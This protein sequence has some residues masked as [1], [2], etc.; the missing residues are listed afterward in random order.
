MPNFL[1]PQHTV[2]GS[3][4]MSGLNR[5][6]HTRKEGGL[7]LFHTSVLNTKC[8]S[9]QIKINF[10]NILYYSM[11]FFISFC[12]IVLLYVL[13]G[14]IYSLFMSL[15]Q[16]NKFSITTA[17]KIPSTPPSDI[18]S[19][20]WNCSNRRLSFY[21]F[22]KSSNLTII[23]AIHFSLVSYSVHELW[24]DIFTFQYIYYDII[25]ISDNSWCTKTFKKSS[26]KM[27]WN[28]CLSVNFK[29]TGEFNEL[30]ICSIHVHLL[31]W[32][33]VPHFYYSSETGSIQKKT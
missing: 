3:R 26:K 32:K 10:Y 19:F 7:T 33:K 2:A 1:Q 25:N 11:W 24:F 17:V 6:G 27:S 22:F 28:I 18:Q 12:L 5:E 23:V 8:T 14:L 31:I 29:S 16:W 15:V 9:V 30:N 21:V 4:I 20:L 13:K